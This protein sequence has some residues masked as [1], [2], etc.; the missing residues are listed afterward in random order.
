V[1]SVTSEAAASV[2]FQTAQLK[3][4]RP[5][6]SRQ[7]DSFGAMVESSIPAEA[8]SDA[9]ASAA[10]QSSAS[11]RRA[12]NADASA[13]KTRSG[14]ASADRPAKNASDDRDATARESYVHDAAND[15]ANSA[16]LQRPRSKSAGSKESTTESTETPSSDATSA[17]DTEAAA[18]QDVA[19]VAIPN[20]V[21]VAIAV[22]I[23]ATGVPAA[24]TSN[25]SNPAPLAIAAAAI[26]SSAATEPVGP[27]APTDVIPDNTAVTASLTAAAPA[28]DTAPA[29]IAASAAT[30]AA[31][32]NIPL[33]AAV[34]ETVAAPPKQSAAQSDAAATEAGLT[35]AAAISPAPPKPGPLKAAVAA[36]PKTA[37]SG[38]SDAELDTT[39]STATATPA[40]PQAT[41]PQTAAAQPKAGDEMS[42][43]ATSERAGNAS[44]A[45]AA[46]VHDHVPTT[47]TP[48][49][50]IDLVAPGNQ[51]GT[52][53]LQP[54]FSAAAAPLGPLYV[55]AA[56]GAAVPLSG[57][58]VEIAASARSGKS[59]FEIRLDPADLGRIDVRIDVDRNGQVTSHLTVEKPATLSMLRQD[60]PQLQRALD[61]AGFKTGD[62]GLQFSLRDQSSS[63][64]NERDE[65]G[66]NAQRL[67]ISDEETIPA[68]V[69]GRSY[70]RMLGS[71]SGVDLRV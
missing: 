8:G 31:S 64:H 45:P 67:V 69:A 37:A 41:L 62:A 10:R 68:V 57:L 2:S 9:V 54:Q 35:E 56:T 5:D 40:A 65:T 25:G 28:S 33:Q 38:A 36:P 70:G 30:A 4:G 60:A 52:G 1:F 7:N 51:G 16:A 50:A 39:D 19:S 11:E 48:D 61:D 23:I 32:E 22:A 29:F 3:A 47:A 17:T 18:E 14:Q 43:A 13:D 21:A 66:R 42:H 34:G 71:S 55:T 26:A 6:Q 59:H 12:A 24:G 58:A 20:A 63:G 53:A 44:S 15:D 27:P 46:P 49:A